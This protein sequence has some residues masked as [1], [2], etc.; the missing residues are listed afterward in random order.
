MAMFELFGVGRAWAGAF[1]ADPFE[2]RRKTAFPD[3]PISAGALTI[4]EPSSGSST[5]AVRERFRTAS[6]SLQAAFGGFLRQTTPLYT[7]TRS[8]NR[9]T[10]AIVAGTSAR[11]DAVGVDYYG[12]QASSEVNSRTSTVRTS[13]EAIGLDVTT[14]EAASL[15]ASSAG[16]NL[17]VVGASSVKMSKEELN[18]GVT[19]SYGSSSLAFTGSGAASTSAGSLTGTYKGT[20][21]AEDATSLQ[22]TVTKGGTL[23][24]SFLGLGETKIEFEVRDQTGEKIFSYSGN[25]AAG[26]AVSLGNDIGLTIAFGEGELKTGHQAS[27]T[28]ARTPITVDADARFDA[29]PGARPQFEAVAAVTA[30]SFKINGTVIEVYASDT[31]NTVLDRITSSAAGVTATLSGD[32]V[33]LTSKANS[34][35]NI[36]VGN[37]SSGFVKAVRLDGATTAKGN[38]RDDERLL[39]DTAV[40]RDIRTGSFTINGR[41]ISINKDQDT[42]A[43]VLARING[44][45]AGVTASLNLTTNK[46]EIVTDSP[47]E[48]LIAVGSDTTGLLGMARLSTSNTVVGNIRDDRQTLSKTSRFAGITS[49]SFSVNGVSIS[50]N[51]ATDSLSSIVSRVNASGAGVTVSYDAGTDRLTFTPDVEGATLSIDSDTTGLLAAVKVASGTAATHANADAAF[52]ATG[53]SGPLLDPG[54]TVRAGSFSINGVTI[55]VAANDSIDTVL[56]R[57][58]ASGAGVTATYDDSTDRVTLTSNESGTPITFGGDSSGFL[59]A[60]KLDGSATTTVSTVNYSSFKTALGEMA[61]YSGVTTGTLTVNGQDVA[62]DPMS[63]TIT[64]LVGTLNNLSGVSASVDQIS[65][66]IRIWSDASRSL[67]LS[68]TSGLL[69]ALGIDAGTYTGR[70]GSLT[71]ATTMTGESTTSNAAEVAANITSAVAELNEALESVE[72]ADLREA[73]QGAIDRLRDRGIRGLD[74]APGDEQTTVAVG[75]AEL[76]D[77]LEAADDDADLEK[78]LSTVLE[79]L[80][81]DI[82]EAAGWNAS[83]AAVQS[84][85]L[86]S[87]SSAQLMA[88]HA[89]GG[90]LSVRSSLQPQQPAAT[91]RQTVMKAYGTS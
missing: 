59:A 51:S 3:T 16:L 32:K 66:G 24:P 13:W 45:G 17:D 11:V 74:L 53:V 50:V 6:G 38:L 67:S 76:I 65:G 77:S 42:L 57:I 19:T 22:I 5:G 75:T 26:E 43:M 46:I 4:N 58:T 70:A 33:T 28:V 34:D 15:L 79:A 85:R 83:A 54:Q 39:K 1:K 41:T 71:T 55:A 80:E 20:G 73:I 25:L 82:A 87:V 48:E 56:A 81:Q 68:D 62:I 61:E 7:T 8:G 9:A 23:K 35:Q 12:L 31:I 72:G 44:S 78:T 2:E 69:D 27:T 47:S 89:A 86:D 18:T 37:D 49:G 29:A 14:P 63:T 64:G 90:L 84:I 52:N 21:K 10:A 30:G 36:D 40:F 60:V 88:D 91:T